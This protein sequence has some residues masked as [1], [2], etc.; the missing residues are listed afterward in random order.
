V[1]VFA[2]WWEAVGFAIQEALYVYIDALSLI[3][4]YRA[5]D[6]AT[7]LTTYMLE[8][9]G[10]TAVSSAKLAGYKAAVAAATAD[11]TATTLQTMVTTVNAA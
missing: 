6:D 9:A 3:N 2:E 7:N 8:D 11:Y 10:C 4:E 5:A 1:K